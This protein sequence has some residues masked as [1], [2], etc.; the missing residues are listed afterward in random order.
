MTEGPQGSKRETSRP[1]TYAQVMLKVSPKSRMKRET[2]S[3]D[4]KG[5]KSHCMGAR[6]LGGKG[7]VALST[8][9]GLES[10]FLRV[11]LEDGLPQN[12]GGH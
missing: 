11:L 8:M 9:Q 7:S 4:V 6:A 10:A 3:L 12:K 5:A 1:S 2:L